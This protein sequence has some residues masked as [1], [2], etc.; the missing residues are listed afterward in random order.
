MNKLVKI[1]GA[2][3]LTA[4]MAGY[5]YQEYHSR[6]VVQWAQLQAL[7][8]T[9]AGPNEQAY[10]ANEYTLRDMQATVEDNH[11][12]AREIALLSAARQV[13][14][15]TRELLDTLW[16]YRERLMRQT[17]NQN[18]VNG[19]RHPAT[20][21][22]LAAPRDNEQQP[23]I[24][25]QLGAYARYI[26]ALQIRYPAD[27]LR[28]LPPG[29]PEQWSA[30]LLYDKQPVGLVLAA[31]R[32]AEADALTYEAAAL[33]WLSQPLEGRRIPRKL[34]AVA[35]AKANA[36]A[37]GDTYK[38]QIYLVNQLYGARFSMSCNGQPIAVASN[39]MGEVR[40]RTPVNIGAAAWWL[41]TVRVR[42]QGRDSTFE[43]RVPYH[44]ARP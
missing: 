20:E 36:V 31:I 44:V 34:I 39:G 10:K 16:W 19:W 18:A 5:A 7:D 21:V 1:L 25:G 23:S 11:K 12:Q 9:L 6:Q 38:A 3:L 28:P 32:Q 14:A 29:M 17:G 41:G 13:H 37:P 2:S 43:V 4:G 15:R 35:T 26:Q 24:Q 42:Y 22:T 27:S 33:A 40:F 30:P 8:D